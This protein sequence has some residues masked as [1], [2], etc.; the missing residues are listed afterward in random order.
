MAS[1]PVT[2]GGGVITPDA[3]TLDL[4]VASL[5]S[6]GIAYLLDL[7]LFLFG[8]ILF[9]LIQLAF[10]GGEWLDSGLGVALGLLLLF[11]WQFGYPISLETLW[12][13][14]T[15][16]KAA[17][18]LRVVTVEGAPVGVRHATIR[19]LAAPF[20]LLLAAGLIGSVTAF[21]S[22][23]GQRLGDLAAGTLVVR[24]RR[25]APEPEARTFLAPP[26]AEPFLAQLD[27]TAVG[28]REYAL[29][30]DTLVRLETME[31]AVA[32]QLAGEV[33]GVIAA[34]V[35]PPPPAGTAA[36][37]YLEAVAVAVQRRRPAVTAR[38]PSAPPTH[39][40][41]PPPGATVAPGPLAGP[42]SSPAA[43]PPLP[44]G[45]PPGAP[46]GPPAGTS[47]GPGFQQPA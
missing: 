30:R 18:G 28:A 24:E 12:R 47:P 26:G 41:S 34:R 45:P 9:S 44:P 16:G 22:P 42:T 36:Q 14:R 4:E 40:S 32:D 6:R 11:A 19:A 3:V 46:S 27:V 5:G 15:L 13:G 21:I 43:A 7:T 31:G 35:H 10:L 20:E 29:V 39:A 23:R 8:A 1:T 37:P 2:A 25:I 33:A 17:M 38:P